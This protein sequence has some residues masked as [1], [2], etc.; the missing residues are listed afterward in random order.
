MKGTEAFGSY[1]EFERPASSSAGYHAI[2]MRKYLNELSQSKFTVAL[3]A[4]VFALAGAFFALRPQPYHAVATLKL[5]G[6]GLGGII[7][8]GGLNIDSEIGTINSWTT[9]SKVLDRMQYYAVVESEKRPNWFSNFMNVLHS[10]QPGGAESLDDKPSIQVKHLHLPTVLDGQ[11][12]IFKIISINTYI[13]TTADNNIVFT[14][15]F[16]RTY[17]DSNANIADSRDS[18][19][20]HIENHNAP[21]G[22]LFYVNP[23]S[24]DAMITHVLQ[25]MDVTKR[26]SHPN[27]SLIDVDIVHYNPQFARSFLS[28]LVDYYIDS[29]AS[30][31]NASSEKIRRNFQEEISDLKQQIEHREKELTRFFAENGT[32]NIQEETKLLLNNILSL[33]NQL[34]EAE[35]ELAQA[36]LIYQNEH[37][38]LEILKDRVIRLRA[39]LENIER[40]GE[41]LPLLQSRLFSLQRELDVATDLYSAAIE[42]YARLEAQMVSAA[43]Q[44]HIVNEPRIKPDAL[45]NQLAQVVVLSVIM[46]ILIALSLILLRLTARV[47][48]IE[49][50][51]DLQSISMFPVVGTVPHDKHEA[52]KGSKGQTSVLFSNRRSPT[53]TNLKTIESQFHY[54][55]HGANNNVVAFTSDVEGQGKSFLA[56]N[57]ALLS[58]SRR[59][60]LFIDCDIKHSSIHKVLKCARMP[61]LSDIIT[62]NTNFEDALVEI[63]EEKFYYLPPGLKLMNYQPLM[64]KRRLSDL[65]EK[66]SKSFDIVI[67]DFPAFSQLHGRTDL[68]D[69]AGTLFHVVKHGRNVQDLELYLEKFDDDNQVNSLLLNNVPNVK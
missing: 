64:D 11:Q 50:I 33:E 67:I 25:K 48:R 44:A 54:L 24:T 32:I 60:T 30:Q 14:G 19:I 13:L 43:G 15:E 31:K 52:Q 18:F 68:L 12:L 17:T 55:T 8:S 38:S 47:Q 7:Q 56:L 5:E 40:R 63:T 39:R 66:T 9:V 62:G 59:K 65:I 49:T 16:G 46:G 28:A 27:S 29:T 45:R 22:S 53:I 34:L 23:L 41:S 51:D 61:G 37:P 20:I 69:A 3:F 21:I 6:S 42:R 36:K 2:D 58:A 26:S 35:M 1:A 57:L 4:F 10:E